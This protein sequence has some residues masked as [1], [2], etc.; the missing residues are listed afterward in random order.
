MS[1]HNISIKQDIHRNSTPTYDAALSDR[2]SRYEDIID[3]ISVVD[4]VFR[5]NCLRN[6]E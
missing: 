4:P 3:G 2:I 5:K 1:K 6:T